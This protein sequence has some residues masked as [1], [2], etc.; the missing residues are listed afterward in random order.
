MLAGVVVDLAVWGLDKELTYSVP[1]EL[2]E[3]VRIGSIVRVPLR[4]RRV[5]G[6]VVSVDPESPVPQGVVAIAAV[7]GRGPVFDAELLQMSRA[8]ARRYVHPLSSFLSLFT[9]VRLG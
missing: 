8:L 9:P 5:R 3:R 6:W 2:A 7:S 4:N 1:P